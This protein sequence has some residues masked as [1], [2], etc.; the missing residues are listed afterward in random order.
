MLP[1]PAAVQ[2]PPP[3]PAHVHVQVRPGGKVSATVAP[4]TLTGPLLLATIVYVVEP[5][6]ATVVT[7]LVLVIARSASPAANTSST[8]TPPIP[9]AARPSPRITIR[10]GPSVSTPRLNSTTTLAP[11]ASG[12][13]GLITAAE[14]EEFTPPP[15]A[16]A[17][18]VC[19]VSAS[20]STVD[21]SVSVIVCAGEFST[22]RSAR[23]ASGAPPVRVESATTRKRSANR[24]SPVLF[25]YLRRIFSV[26]RVP[27]VTGVKSRTRLG[28]ATSA[29]AGSIRAEVIAPGG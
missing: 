3:A 28:A 2:V 27:L 4:V 6:A 14:S 22:R 20:E 16:W 15:K 1:D 8:L 12:A 21:A 17:A 29:C 5:P 7:P 10:Y 18:G 19:T 26:P 24:G 13:T 9:S 25:V 11:F 23:P